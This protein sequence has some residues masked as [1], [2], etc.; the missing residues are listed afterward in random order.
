MTVGGLLRKECLGALAPIPVLASGGTGDYLAVPF[1]YSQKIKEQTLWVV[2]LRGFVLIY[3]LSTIHF[4][5]FLFHFPHQ[6]ISLY[7][8]FLL[9]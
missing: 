5:L 8:L 9:P 2:N 6:S 7:L 4:L 3:S 1:Q